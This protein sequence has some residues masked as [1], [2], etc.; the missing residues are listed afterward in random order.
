MS[1]FLSWLSRGPGIG[2]SWAPHNRRDRRV[3]GSREILWDDQ[4]QIRACATLRDLCFKWISESAASREA[5]ARGPGPSPA[6]LPRPAKDLGNSAQRG[7]FASRGNKTRSRRA[8]FP[9]NAE[10]P[11]SLGRRRE[12]AGSRVSE[13]SRLPLEGKVGWLSRRWG[14]SRT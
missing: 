11:R 10:F 2:A 3:M 5:P 14:E 12:P 4:W 13:A 1:C 8:D 7:N 6:R 9:R